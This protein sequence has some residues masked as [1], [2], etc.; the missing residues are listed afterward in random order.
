MSKMQSQIRNPLQHVL[1]CVA[2][3]SH[4]DKLSCSRMRSEH[5]ITGNAGHRVYSPMLTHTG[6]GL[7]EQDTKVLP[8]L[9]DINTPMYQGTSHR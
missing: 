8:T 1:A 7:S 9:N 6:V 5:A 2:T 3:A 4:F